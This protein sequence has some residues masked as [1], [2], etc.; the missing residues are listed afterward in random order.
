MLCA[1]T[2]ARLS[3]LLFLF[4]WWPL[5]VLMKQ[6]RQAVHAFKQ[7]ILLR[8][9]WLFHKLFNLMLVLQRWCCELNHFTGKMG[10]LPNAPCLYGGW[11]FESHQL[12][13]VMEQHALNNVNNCL[14]TNIYSHIE[15]SGGQIFN[16]YRTVVHFST[17]VLSQMSNLWQA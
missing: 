14:N 17:Q 9:L 8:C 3:R 4:L 10:G 12:I 6:T 11:F 16:L 5:T 13:K 7:S 2:S 15:T 1:A